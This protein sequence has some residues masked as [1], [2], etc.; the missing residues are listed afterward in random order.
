[1]AVQL[2]DASGTLRDALPAVA[3]DVAGAAVW[4]PNTLAQPDARYYPQG[5][6]EQI[7][8]V[9]PEPR[10]DGETTP[11]LEV[12]VPVRNSEGT[13]SFG[14][15]RYWI[16]GREIAGE[17][18]RLDQSLL[19]QAGVGYAGGAVLIAALLA[20]SYRRLTQT[21]RQLLEK[22]A[23]LERANQELDF[24][25]KTGALGAISAHLIHGIKNP[26]A[27]L[28]GFV[29]ESAGTEDPGELGAARRT[30]LETARRLR[31]L[32]NDVVSV[33][34]DEASGEADYQVPV[35]ETLQAVQFRATPA[36][37]ARGV[38]IVTEP[39]PA[40]N[41]PARTAN[42]AGLVL[43]NLVM[44]AVEASPRGAE[45]R[46]KANSESG[47]IDFVVCDLGAGLPAIVRE[48]LFRPVVSAKPNGGGMG[49]AISARLARHAGGEL[50]L[51]RSDA[52]GTVFRLALSATT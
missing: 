32:V 48:N 43:A 29:T 21:H 12:V 7:L 40:A 41:L 1:M 13:R 42:L 50:S 38:R 6:L 39:A 45:V 25:A 24:A 22:T 28:E 47:H 5:H 30:A 8:G 49:L 11:L 3:N 17:F 2:F 23:D 33:L 10:A 9:A 37:H 27:G 18:H 20:W 35:A 44:N 51:V 15:A 16:D 19:T 36:A 52:T 46:L 26:L 14:I 31:E 34:R 4:W